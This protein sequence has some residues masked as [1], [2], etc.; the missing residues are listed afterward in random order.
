MKS[1]TIRHLHLAKRDLQY[2]GNSKHLKLQFN[3]ASGINFHVFV[4]KSYASHDDRKSQFG[5]SIHSNNLSCSCI[6]ISKK[7]K[8]LAFLSTEAEYLALMR[9]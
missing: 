2:I 1:T 5:V 7:A 4:D 3:D 9:H 6:T 8:L